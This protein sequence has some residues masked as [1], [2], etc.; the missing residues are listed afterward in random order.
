MI[1]RECAYAR[2]CVHVHLIDNRYAVPVYPY[3]V[4]RAHA[5]LRP[6]GYKM[7]CGRSDVLVDNYL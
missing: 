5:L 2:V 7:S 6:A 1:M 3:R 4:P